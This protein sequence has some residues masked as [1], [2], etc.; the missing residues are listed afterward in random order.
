MSGILP[1]RNCRHCG[2][3]VCGD[4]NWCSEHETVMSD[5]E[6]KV[7]RKCEEWMFN[8]I[9][10]LTGEEWHRSKPSGAKA[11]LDGQMAFEVTE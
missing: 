2:H 7:W 5:L 1:P 4:A 11:V 8:E 6:I 10:A 9:D 3:M